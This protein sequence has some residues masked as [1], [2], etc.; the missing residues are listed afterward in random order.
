[1]FMGEV[2]QYARQAYLGTGPKGLVRATKGSKLPHPYR[3]I[4]LIM[5][6]A[7]TTAGGGNGSAKYISV[8]GARGGNDN[9]KTSASPVNG[10][11]QQQYDNSG[12][13]YHDGGA[14]V[15]S[16]TEDQGDGYGMEHCG[17][18]PPGTF[19]AAGGYS[20]KDEYVY[21]TNIILDFMS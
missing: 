3:G 21:P 4:T 2:T 12:G 9:G 7:L 19:G 14:G 1:M 6:A 8:V 15:N 16:N 20:E 10:Q 5:T 17:A 18:S 13:T 11:Q